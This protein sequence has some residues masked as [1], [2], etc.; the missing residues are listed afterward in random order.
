M[1]LPTYHVIG[2]MAQVID[3]EK[4]NRESLIDNEKPLNDDNIP[5]R[6]VRRLF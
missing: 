1:A 6:M 3:L 4:S 5:L 2:H